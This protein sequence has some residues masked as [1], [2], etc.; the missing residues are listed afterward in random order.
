MRRLGDKFYDIE[1]LSGLHIMAMEKLIACIP[2]IMYDE[3]LYSHLIHETLSFH[4]DMCHLHDYPLG[5]ASCLHVLTAE[6]PFKKWILIEKKCESLLSLAGQVINSFEYMLV[7]DVARGQND[8]LEIFL[9][10]ICQTEC[11]Q[12]CH[13]YVV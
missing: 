1:I 10:I 2:E 3:H 5:E 4:T 13:W 12:R 11:L 9:D 6:E 7:N 8:G